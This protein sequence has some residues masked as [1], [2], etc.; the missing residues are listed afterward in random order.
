MWLQLLAKPLAGAAIGWFTNYLAIRML[1][2]P[3]EPR[4]VAGLTFQGVIPRRRGELAARVAEA[5]ERELLSHEDIQAALLDPAF[6]EALRLRIEA[7]LREYLTG[8]LGSSARLVRALVSPELVDRLARGGA[9]EAMRRLPSV[10][11]YAAQE[12]EAHLDIRAVVRSKME[13]FDLERLESLVRE[14]AHRELRFIE[15]LGGVVG[16]VVG[17]ALAAIEHLLA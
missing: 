14:I 10:I 12:L 8:R 1:F 5:I 15:V 4:R 2:R 9:E 11:G 6:Q 13:A 3:R 16:F 7:G 17:A